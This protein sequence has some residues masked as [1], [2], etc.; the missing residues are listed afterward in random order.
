MLGKEFLSILAREDRRRAADS[1][2]EVR[3]GERS[4]KMDLM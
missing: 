1:H 3:L 4:A 2:D